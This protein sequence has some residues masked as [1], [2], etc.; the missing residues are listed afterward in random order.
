MLVYSIVMLLPTHSNKQ[1]IWASVLTYLI[2][3]RLLIFPLKIACAHIA[4]E[5]LVLIGL[6]TDSRLKGIYIA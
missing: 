3:V 5:V 6:I 1:S 2:P 4:R